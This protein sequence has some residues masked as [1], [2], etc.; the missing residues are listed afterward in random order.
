MNGERFQVDRTDIVTAS[1]L[2][3]RLRSSYAGDVVT[4]RVLTIQLLKDGRVIQ[5]Q[6][7][8]KDLCIH[9]EPGV[10]VVFGRN[11]LET[12]EYH[13][14]AG[15]E[16]DFELRIPD[17]VTEISDCAFADLPHVIS[18]ILPES[19]T[20]IAGYA[21]R[22][23]ESLTEVSLPDSLTWIGSSAFRFCQA[24]ETITLPRELSGIG[25]LAFGGCLSLQSIILPEWLRRIEP[26]VFEKCI[27]LETVEIS[28]WVPRALARAPSSAACRC[29]AST[30]LS[31]SPT[32][33]HMSFK[34]V[35]L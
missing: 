15:M 24:L 18:I 7:D 13:I 34:I 27:T 2:K 31:G 8:L 33:D 23:C 17:G 22:G 9:D 35:C 14:T 1:D 29:G 25:L 6:E 4:R 26:L 28:D 10:C 19:V 5:D 21:F 11:T 32:L 3:S 20:E 12:M 16:Q 30:Y